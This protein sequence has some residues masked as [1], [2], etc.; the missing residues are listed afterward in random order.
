MNTSGL[1]QLDGKVSLVTGAGKGI[2]RAIAIG[3]AE[4]GS[5]VVLVARTVEDLEEV[6]KVISKLGRRAL[7]LPADLTDLPGVPLLVERVVDEW[8]R[9]D[10]LVNNAGL[11]IRNDVADALISDWDRITD[12]NLKCMF[13]LSQSAVR[14]MTRQGSGKIINVTSVSSV[15]GMP[16]SALYSMTKGG[17]LQFTRAFATELARKNINVQVNCVAPGAFRTP[18]ARANDKKHGGP[19]SDLRKFIGERIPMG[20]AGDPEEL[21]GAFI[22]LASSASSYITGTT[23]FVDGG[24]TASA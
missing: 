4:A 11:T 1:F 23:I 15:R 12:L 3:L 21:K 6:A 8:G 10:V 19:N 20:R 7:V 14:Y 18:Q 2:G 9:L 13:L 17:I 5:D 24:W 22:L 16:G